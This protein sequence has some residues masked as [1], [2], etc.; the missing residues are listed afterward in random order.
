M[1]TSRTVDWWTLGRK[2]LEIREGEDWLN[3]KAPSNLKELKLELKG[4]GEVILSS[5]CASESIAGT[6]E[7]N[8][9]V[10]Y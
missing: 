4:F 8:C 2:A 5:G 3:A 6:F 7:D 9:A 10:P 1:Q